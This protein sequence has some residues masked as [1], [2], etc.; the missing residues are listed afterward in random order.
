MRELLA[1]AEQG[2]GVII[3]TH[4][5]TGFE[6]GHHVLRLTESADGGSKPAPRRSS[7][8]VRL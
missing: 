4:R 1:A 7:R 5:P 8:R 2:A 3:T 6:R